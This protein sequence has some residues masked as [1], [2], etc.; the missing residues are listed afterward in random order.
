VPEPSDPSDPP[1]QPPVRI[2][3]VTYLNSRP[4][5]WC[6]PRLAPGAEIVFDLPSRLADGLAAARLDVALIPSVEYFRQPGS[7]IVSDACVA[8]DGPVKSVKLYS[9]VP[10]ARIR[11]LALDEGS[12]T[13]AAM[14]R[15]MLKERYGLEP[16]LTP[17]PIGDSVGRVA[18][19]A[20]LLIGDRAIQTADDPFEVVWDLGREWS[21]WTGLPFVFAM[22]IARP[23]V[24]LRG[25]DRLL[26]AARDGG[27]RCFEA[28]AREA[29]PALGIAEAECL[30][31]LRDNLRFE[32]GRRQRLGLETF[33]QLAVR[34]GLAPSGIDLVFYNHRPA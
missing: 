32:L 27:V 31:Y 13:S 15:V 1:G 30:T 18:A 3:A 11:T 34:H 6:L 33:Y 8:C 21:E 20:V 4:L 5:V 29:A 16:E 26:A 9:R 10:V 25:I 2:G 28:I 19:D 23:C 22:W 17:L 7:T 12:R 24:H 14:V